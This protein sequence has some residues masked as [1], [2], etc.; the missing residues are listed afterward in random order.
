[1][2]ASVYG[3]QYL[4]EALFEHGDTD[5]ALGLMTTNGPRGWLNMIHMG[6][7]LTTEAWN[8]DDKTNMDYNHAWGAA[9]GNL[10]SRFVLGVRP[11]DP[12]YGQILIQPQLGRTLTYVQGT[13]PTIRGPISIQATNAPGAF[14]LLVSI[15]GNVIATVLLPAYGQTNSTAMVDGHLVSG[16]FSGGLLTVSNI[17]SGRHLIYLGTKNKPLQTAFKGN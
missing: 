8:F 15:P 2:P 5:T 4:L 1:M 3:A 16:A 12:G 13:V 17:G 10:I 11:L 14:Q 6:S 9:P 7:T